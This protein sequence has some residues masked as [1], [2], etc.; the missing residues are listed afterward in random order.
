MKK[1]ITIFLI[2]VY[3]AA[4]MGIM[5]NYHY[6]HG[7]LTHASILIFGEQ[8]GCSCNSSTMPKGCCKDKMIFLKGDHHQPS[9]LF[10]APLQTTFTIG[11]PVIIDKILLQSEFFG[12]S[13]I[14]CDFVR[15]K[16]PQ[17]IFLL[18]SVFRI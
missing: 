9:S 11:L 3:A 17:P 13:K 12:K 2:L 8:N 15:Q 6:C 10:S 7:H 16:S 4:S 5:V 14:T 18:N 1:T